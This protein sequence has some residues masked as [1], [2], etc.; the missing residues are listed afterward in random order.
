MATVAVGAAWVAM[1][2]AAEEK[3]VEVARG[4][5]IRQHPSTAGRQPG[6]SSPNRQQIPCTIASQ[7]LH[8]SWMVYPPEGHAQTYR[9]Q[10]AGSKITRVSCSHQKLLTPPRTRSRCSRSHKCPRANHKSSHGFSNSCK[11]DRRMWASMS[12]YQKM[13]PRDCSR[14][15]WCMPRL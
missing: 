1:G 2:A 11:F 10:A 4:W 3:A 14:C 7:G 12:T 9:S 13:R 8:T 5:Y 6:L 15:Q